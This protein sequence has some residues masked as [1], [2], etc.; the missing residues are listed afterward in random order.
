MKTFAEIERAC[1]ALNPHE[2]EGFVVVDASF[3]RRKLKSPAYVGL[4]LL[5]SRDTSA[6]DSNMLRIV[7]QN[8]TDEFTSYY[9]QWGVLC[10]YVRE[11]YDEMIQ[12]LVQQYREPMKNPPALGLRKELLFFIGLLF[13]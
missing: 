1:R 7:R 2:N 5:S 3:R 12:S 11:R 13:C 6:N 8:E 9:P 4:S 10:T